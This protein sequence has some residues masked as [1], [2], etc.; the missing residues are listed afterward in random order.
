LIAGPIAKNP[1]DAI[2]PNPAWVNLT[3]WVD[4]PERDHRG[5]RGFRS[6]H[7]PATG[8]NPTLRPILRDYM[9]EKRNKSALVPSYAVNASWSTALISLAKLMKKTPWPAIALDPEV[10]KFAA[11]AYA[12]PF[13]DL[14]LSAAGVIGAAAVWPFLFIPAV[15]LHALITASVVSK[16]RADEAEGDAV[17]E[18]NFTQAQKDLVAGF[19]RIKSRD[20]LKALQDLIYE[21][22]SLQPVLSRRRATD[23]IAVGQLPVLA[24]E[25]YRQG[26]SVL[27]DALDLIEATTPEDKARL[28]AEDRDIQQEI[29]D[30]GTEDAQAARVKIRRDRLA[31]NKELLALIEKQ[32]ERID[33]LLYQCDRCAASL[34]RTRMDLAALRADSSEDSVTSVVDTLRQTISHARGVQDEMKRLTSGSGGLGLSSP[35]ARGAAANE[36]S[37][38]DEK[39]GEGPAADA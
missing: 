25:A 12:I 33:E 24:E 22:N 23:S 15:G 30:L 6:F 9:R 1:S 18:S 5:L 35:P 3:G 21:Y 4:D 29:A 26:I 37:R 32:Q 7:L 17:T 36:A 16:H 39:A 28:E 11:P 2:R 19:D 20:G 13:V 27:Q 14:A 38:E 34:H 10:L 31:S 8:N